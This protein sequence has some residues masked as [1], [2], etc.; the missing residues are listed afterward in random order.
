MSGTLENGISLVEGLLQKGYQ[1]AQFGMAG[2]L[3]FDKYVQSNCMVGYG[4]NEVW[5][6]GDGVIEI[7][8]FHK[9]GELPDMLREVYS[10]QEAAQALRDVLGWL[11]PSGVDPDELVKQFTAHLQGGQRGKGEQSN[12]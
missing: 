8:T 1:H 6:Y 2:S 5:V 7:H 9:P 11:Q 3:A 4:C 12:G 10:P